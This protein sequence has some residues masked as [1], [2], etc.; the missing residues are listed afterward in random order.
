MKG[1]RYSVSRLFQ[2]P[3]LRDLL[4]PSPAS[5]SLIDEQRV[6]NLYLQAATQQW[7]GPEK[8]NFNEIITLD[9]RT[10]LAWLHL[11]TVFYT[12][13]K[14]GLNV[15][16]NM[17]AKAVRKLRSDEAAF[18]LSAQC[19]DEAR[20]VFLLAT[21]L[22]K[23][24]GSP[25]YEKLYG[26]LGK[27]ASIGAYRVENWLFSTLFSENFASA[28][29]KHAQTAQIDPIGAELC[30][31]LLLDETRHLHFLHAVLP[32]LLDRLS[33]LGKSY[34]RAT[35]F[36]IMKFT[37]VA[38]RSLDKDAGVVGLNRHSLLEEVFSNVERSYRNF[39]LNTRFLYFPAI[40][41]I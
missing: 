24:G 40:A 2:D 8:I 36:F 30:K 1:S 5:H 32:D 28:F 22:R 27:A 19:F 20:H 23:L 33:V 39:G 17:M 18:Y 37:E 3:A 13:E 15:I 11:T 25:H 26:V 9:E 12:L 38:A 10:R 29:L 41:K 35:Q 4:K 14:M 21:Y 34:V 31:N 16:E 7:F 6:R